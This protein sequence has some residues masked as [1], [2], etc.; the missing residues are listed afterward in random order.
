MLAG[1]V[2]H[3]RIV[4]LGCGGDRD[5]DKRGPMGAAAA[6]RT[7]TSWWSPTTTRGPRIRRRSGP[8][9]LA[10]RTR[11]G[12]SGAAGPSTVLDGGDRRDAIAAALAAAGPDDVVGG[13]GQGPRTRARR[14]RAEVLPF[15]DDDVVR[16][17]WA[18][19]HAH[20]LRGRRAGPMIPAGRS[21]R[22]S[23][24][25]ARRRGRPAAAG[26]AGRRRSTRGHR[27]GGRLPPGR[28][29]QPVPRPA[30][31]AR[32]RAR[33]RGHG[34]RAPARS[35]RSPR[36]RCPT[37]AVRAWWSRTRCSPLGRLARD[38]VDRAVAGGLRVV[39]IT[40]S[41]GQDLD[42]GPAGPGAGGGRADGR[43]G[44][45]PE[46]RAR[47]AVDGL[48]DRRARPASWW[49]RWVLAAS[50]TSPTCARSRRRRSPRCSTSGT[51]PRGRVRRPAAD[52]PR[53]GRDR[54][55]AARRRDG[56]AERRRPAGL[57][58]ADPDARPG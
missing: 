40:G 41:A 54:R 38:Q 15:A 35:P 17:V 19:L 58:H 56:G 24:I 20:A 25:L 36:V 57:G 51:R 4:V 32:G 52:R 44:R 45:Q 8:Q 22:S 13:A 33:L 18:E 10:G 12:C 42:Q 47:T 2:G 6:A 43:A 28:R 53:Q 39:A 26:A 48:P 29:R 30:G 7:P 49:P 14:S 55:G 5:P 3:R 37:P 31:R 27:S 23:R 50:A 16:E 46:Q 1:L 21:G 11:R 34:L 9:V